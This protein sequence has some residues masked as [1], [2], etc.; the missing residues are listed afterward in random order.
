MKIRD[1]IEIIERCDPL[2]LAEDQEKWFK[3]GDEISSIAE[4]A[5][6]CQSAEE[7]SK[8]IFAVFFEKFG[9]SAHKEVER[10]RTAAEEAWM[11]LNKNPGL[12]QTLRMRFIINKCDP[13]GLLAM[14]A[15]EDEYDRVME[16]IMHNAISCRSIDELASL[17]HTEFEST[18]MEL[19]HNEQEKYRRAAEGLWE[20]SLPRD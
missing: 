19:T 4:A 5:V 8:L 13:A 16:R 11:L 17:I 10:Y 15:P 20:L 14:G 12:L 9:N 6:F 1:W 2:C 7:I 18:F 3:H